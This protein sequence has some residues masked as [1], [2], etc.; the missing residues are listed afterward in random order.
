MNLQRGPVAMA[1]VPSTH[2]AFGVYAKNVQIKV[3]GS[4][5]L[6]NPPDFTAFGDE[7]DALI[8]ADGIPN[9]NPEQAADRDAKALKVYRHIGRIVD[10]VQT[11]ADTQP[12]AADAVT[13]ILGAGLDVRKRAGH[14]KAVLAAR[15]TGLTGE[16]LLAALA[17]AG[18][19]AY[20]WEYS[21]DQ[22][23]WVAVP[24]TR[25]PQTKLTGLTPGRKYYF[26]FHALTPKG[27]TDPVEP[28]SLV[29]H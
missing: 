5:A 3:K 15:Y 29:V 8:L 17:I 2:K 13:V 10:Y 14:K 24:E 25:Q 4:A 11:V 1:R 27:K 6:P 20:Y 23:V 21:L 7:V 9:K 28:V 16:V 12:S 18:A 26:R 22:L 19:G